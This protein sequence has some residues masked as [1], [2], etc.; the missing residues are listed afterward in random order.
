[1]VW[2]GNRTSPSKIHKQGWSFSLQARHYAI[3]KGADYHVSW[4]ISLHR[5]HVWNFFT[6][7]TTKER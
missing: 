2:F 4:T 6:F 7:W 3:Q 5:H 1:M